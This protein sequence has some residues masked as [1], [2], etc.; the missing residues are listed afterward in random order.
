[1]SDRP[2]TSPVQWRR[3]VPVGLL[4][5]IAAAVVLSLSLTGSLA[6]G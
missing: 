5:G 3:Y 4:A 2:R 6:G 1:M